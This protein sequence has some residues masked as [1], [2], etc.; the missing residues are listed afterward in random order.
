VPS[1]LA[2]DQRFVQAVLIAYQ[3]LTQNGLD[4][5]L[6]VLERN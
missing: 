6:A 3:K 4:E 5:A 1:E 2:A